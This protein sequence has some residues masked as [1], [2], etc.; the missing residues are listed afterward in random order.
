MLTNNV[1]EINNFFLFSRNPKGSANEFILE[2]K[3]SD[4]IC[5]SGFLDGELYVSAP[6]TRVIKFA[7]NSLMVKTKTSEYLQCTSPCV[8]QKQIQK[9][10]EQ[11]WFC[12]TFELKFDSQLYLKCLALQ[13]SKSNSVRKILP[14]YSK[15]LCQDGNYLKTDDGKWVFINWGNPSHGISKMKQNLKSWGVTEFQTF[16]YT[17]GLRPVLRPVLS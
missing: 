10:N 5:V 3:V 15:V 16:C 12:K 8:E 11:Y 9:I 2:S 17:S 1:K 6:I 14:I 7:E 13:H 4:S